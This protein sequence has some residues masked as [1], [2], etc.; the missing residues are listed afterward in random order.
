MEKGFNQKAFD[1]LKNIIDGMLGKFVMEPIKKK[2]HIDPK[3][4]EI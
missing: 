2:D 4:F 1:D 3:L